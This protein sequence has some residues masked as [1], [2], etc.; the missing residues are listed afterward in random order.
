MATN[1][2]Y[3]PPSDPPCSTDVI[4]AAAAVALRNAGGLDVRCHYFVQGPTIGTPGNTSATIVELHAVTPSSFGKEA[5]VSQT[6]NPEGAF[7]GSYDP[8]ADTANGGTLNELLDHWGNRLTDE[9]A[10]NAATH[11]VHNQWP[12]HLSGPLLRDNIADDTDLPGLAAFV[13]AGG[14]FRDNELRETSVD[15]TGVTSPGPAPASF[16]RRNVINTGNVTLH[17][18]TVYI[19]NNA[20]NNAS[21]TH[22]GTGAGSFSL[23]NNTF[24]TGVVDVDA[25]TT[26]QVTVNNN[27]FGGVTGGYHL[28]V[29]GKTNGPAIFSGNRCFNSAGSPTAEATLGGSA[30]NLTV[31]S[32]EIGQGVLALSSSG[33]VSLTSCDLTNQTITH[34][35]SGTLTLSRLRGKGGIITHGGG[36][37]LSGTDTAM[38]AG[39]TVRTLAGQSGNVILSQSQFQRGYVV[40]VAATST[41]ALTLNSCR[42][43]GHTSHASGLDMQVDGSGSRA[44]QDS[45]VVAH[46][47]QVGLVL[48][49]SGTVSVGGG[50]SILSGRLVRDPATSATLSLSQSKLTGTLQQDAG[51][52]GGQLNLSATDALAAGLLVQQRGTG[53]I[54]FNTCRLG[55]T[56]RNA[57]TA[58]RGLSFTNADLQGGTFD[59]NRTGGNG[60]DSVAS[61]TQRGVLS[62]VALNGAVDPGGNQTPINVATVS[63]GSTLTL[64]DP[65]VT[66]GPNVN[67]QRCTVAEGAQVSGTGTQLVD[68][69]RF[70][71]GAVVDMGA[72]SHSFT[73]IEGQFTKTLTGANNGRLCNAAFDNTV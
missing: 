13:A 36:G 27:V 18:P 2:G 49:G 11:T 15:L 67:V 52:T 16:F 64:T 30:T 59:Q 33:N 60:T 39:S 38:L 34:T 20:L 63:E 72:F 42:F 8:D 7:I 50:S 62:S 51:A 61:L 9:D 28:S 25:A 40:E 65:A 57:A 31:S 23:Q 44:F 32:N 10:G 12:Y 73:V 58:T 55:A 46:F 4:T 56:V 47:N 6:F 1:A 26:S 43:S 24:L 69:C 48:V 5:K 3:N 41:A 68:R 29:Q 22:L 19:N 54:T 71:G 66:G 17:V 35:G 45:E 53:A 37:G 70:A 21:V 14:E